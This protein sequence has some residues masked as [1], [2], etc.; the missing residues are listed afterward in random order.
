ME[1]DLIVECLNKT[2]GNKNETAKILGLSR[3]GLYKKIN[4]Y[5]LR[6]LANLQ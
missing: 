3:A 1:K 2:S 6:E 4:R 5:N